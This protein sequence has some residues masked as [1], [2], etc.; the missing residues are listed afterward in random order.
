MYVCIS[1][2]YYRA[3][4]I[5]VV[6]YMFVRGIERSTYAVFMNLVAIHY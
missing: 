1:V 5:V 4:P 3:W 6:Q 2:P